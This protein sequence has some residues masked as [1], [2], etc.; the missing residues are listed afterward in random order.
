MINNIVNY[1]V[2]FLSFKKF[3][4]IND[5]LLHIIL[6]AKGY[7]NSGSFKD[8][9]EDLFFIKLSK[10]HLNTCLDIGAHSGNYSQ[11][12][13]QKLNTNVIAIEP[14]K[15]PFKD[16]LNIKKKNLYVFFLTIVPFPTK[17]DINL[18]IF[19]IKIHNCPLCV[20]TIMV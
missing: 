6:R 3:Q 8:T 10:F 9:G 7:K 1:L 19:L 14:M 18:F 4:I 20:K 12:L 5:Y 16:L 11:M 15:D 13:I 17:S 2:K